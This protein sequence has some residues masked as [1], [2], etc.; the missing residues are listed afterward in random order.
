MIT[1]ED[2]LEEIVGE[3]RD[4]FDQDEKKEI[5]K[6]DE[7][8]YLVE[9][10]ALIDE[11]N[12]L[13]GINLEHEDVDSIGGWIYA[14]QPDLEKGVEWHYDTLTF[15]VRERDKRRVRK[16][17]IIKHSENVEQVETLENS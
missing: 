10:V 6:I 15:I 5:D 2:I 17:E 1:I 3:I 8:H 12:E 14:Q 11:I 16:V 7:N 4:E 13:L 9:G